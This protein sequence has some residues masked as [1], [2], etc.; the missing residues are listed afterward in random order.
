M[1]VKKLVVITVF[2]YL[3]ACAVQPVNEGIELKNFRNYALSACLGAAFSETEAAADFNRA[4][5]GYM[6]FG[7]MTLEAYEELRNLTKI[8]LAKNYLSKHGGQINSMKCFDLHDSEQVLE[9]Y[10]KNDPCASKEAWMDGASFEEA[11]I[12]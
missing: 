10:K 11:C 5:N 6:E 1:D 7:N 12:D 9:L 2:M 4:L 3:T 8:W